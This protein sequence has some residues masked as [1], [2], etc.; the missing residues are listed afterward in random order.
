MTNLEKAVKYH[1]PLVANVIE[2]TGR[3][4]GV[5]AMAEQYCALAKKVSDLLEAENA[6]VH[7]VIIALERLVDQVLEH[8]L[9]AGEIEI[10]ENP[11]Q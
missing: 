9:D 6:E 7:I 1:A 11:I 3:E 5:D 4:L 10:K 8:L 2:S